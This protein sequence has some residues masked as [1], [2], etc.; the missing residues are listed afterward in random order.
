MRDP[1]DV[2]HCFITSQSQQA[3]HPQVP[4]S[5]A[6]VSSGLAGSA[7]LMSVMHERFPSE[8]WDRA[9]HTHLAAATRDATAEP[10][11]F[12]GLAGLLVAAEIVGG[13]V[14]YAGLRASILERLRR[15]CG[16]FQHMTGSAVSDNAFY[17]LIRGGAGIYIALSASGAVDAC[18]TIAGFFERMTRDTTG[19]S[20]RGRSQVSLEEHLEDVNNAGMS[21]GISGVAAALSLG[22]S[23]PCSRLVMERIGSWLSERCVVTESGTTMPCWIGKDGPQPDRLAWC[24]GSPGTAAAL[25]Q[26]GTATGRPGLHEV[27]ASLLHTIARLPSTARPPMDEALCHGKAGILLCAN[28]VARLSGDDEARSLSEALLTEIVGAFDSKLALGYRAL[29]PSGEG[30][31]SP[32]LLI[33][34][35]GIA[36]TLATAANGEVPGWARLLGLG[37]P[38]APS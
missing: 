10:S 22:P 9:S 13:G 17:E 35:V 19:R 28:V 25:A 2:Q 6:S 5:A 14:A 21:H 29:Y 31:D 20:W 33:G 7:I 12:G 3:S 23:T 18:D 37:C 8:G 34:A 11:L 30:V 38:L 26:A 27:S 16:D 1:D 32:C 24:Y 4:F 15:I 36:L